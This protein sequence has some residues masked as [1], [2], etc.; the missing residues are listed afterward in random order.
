M[1]VVERQLRDFAAAAQWPPAPDVSERVL[2]AISSARPEAPSRRPL[3]RRLFL[4]SFSLEPVRLA[5]IALL[6]AIA[7]TAAV[8][9]ARSAVLRLLGIKGV[10]ITPVKHLPHARPQA[11]LRLG[12]PTTLAAARKASDFGV[13]VPVMLGDPD[14][15]LVRPVVGGAAVTL[16]YRPRPGL[17]GLPGR[18]GIALLLTEFRG[19]STPFMD[20]MRLRTSRTLSTS[21]SGHTAFWLEDPH[22][23]IV[24]YGSPHARITPQPRRLVKGHV[25]LWEDGPVS[26]RLESELPLE[27]ARRIA[28]SLR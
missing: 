25:L 7:V 11:P 22:V 12:T 3:R 13:R 9:A 26:L 16:V 2:L 8:P 27:Q 21:V 6:V 5:L 17:P 20:K 24:R 15:V 18:P 10:E 19:Q 23:I 14:Q 28:R 1:D 4:R